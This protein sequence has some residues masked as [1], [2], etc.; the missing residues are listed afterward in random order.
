[1]VEKHSNLLV[2]LK[3]LS[4]TSKP[5]RSLL[6]SLPV[7][8]VKAHWI[9]L[10]LFL[11][12]LPKSSQRDCMD[13]WFG[14]ST[15]LSCESSLL[16]TPKSFLWFIPRLCTSVEK[17]SFLADVIS[18]LTSLCCVLYNSLWTWR[19]D[20]HHYLSY[21]CLKDFASRICSLYHSVFGRS[22]TDL[23]MSGACLSRMIVS[24]QSK[25]W[26]SSS[27][28]VADRSGEYRL[29]MSLPK[30]ATLFLFFSQYVNMNRMVGLSH[31]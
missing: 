28:P 9:L 13:T 6:R 26:T 27:I 18:S 20:L 29:S 21:F 1:M 24:S 10:I 5:M 15:C 23:E 2:R 17:Y 30:S 14:R 19:P 22:H 16:T 7:A 4:F 11:K 25:T 12:K 3:A 31:V 8:C